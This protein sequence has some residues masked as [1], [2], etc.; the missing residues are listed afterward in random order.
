MRLPACLAAT[1]V[2]VAALSSPA[3]AWDSKILPSAPSCIAY[4][5]DTTAAEL[6]FT[7]TG[8]YNPG[9]AIEKVICTVPRDEE[10]VYSDANALIVDVYYRVIGPTQGRMTCTLFIGSQVQEA[11]TVVSNTATGAFVSGG[12]RTGV[13]M[14]IKSQPSATVFVPTTMVCAIGPKTWMGPINVIEHNGTDS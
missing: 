2:V 12:N 13:E 1:L 3:A 11:A 14:V 4:A 9:T 7:P 6:Q 5:P 10:T 8:I